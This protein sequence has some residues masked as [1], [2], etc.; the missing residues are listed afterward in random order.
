MIE[1]KSQEFWILVLQNIGLVAGL[2]IQHFKRIR[3][4]ERDL[5]AAHTAI[6][7][8]KLKISLGGKQNEE[9]DSSLSKQVPRRPSRIE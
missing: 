7:E 5:N 8:M 4:L 2:V 9:L 3:K 6:R 1:N